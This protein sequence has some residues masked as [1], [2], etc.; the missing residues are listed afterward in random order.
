MR[1]SHATISAALF[2]LT[3]AASSS[4]RGLCYVPSEKK[5]FA[6][7]DAIWTTTPGSDLTWYYNYQAEPSGAYSSIED[8]HFVPMLWGASENDQGTP[9]L[10]SVKRQIGNG[11]KIEYVLGFNEPDG[12]HNIG[13]SDVPA[14]VAAE[15]WKKQM[16]PLKEMGV[17]LGAP[18]VTGS[19]DGL[20]WLENWFKACNGGCNPDFIP[21]HWYGSFEAMA[22]YVGRVVDRYSNMTI[23]VTEWGFPNQELADTQAFFNQSVAMFDRW[24]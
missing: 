15:A 5:E 20:T 21:V 2:T 11:A 19:E 17:K 8:L 1:V 16:E 10:D 3:A 24:E 22:S 6:G 18:A 9:F 4:K 13:G 14:S 12:K 23:W 7:D